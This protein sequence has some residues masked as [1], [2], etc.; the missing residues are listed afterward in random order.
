MMSNN[1]GSASVEFSSV[2]ASPFS[3]TSASPNWRITGAMIDCDGTLIDSIDA[4]RGI[5]EM[6]A[7]LVG[8]DVSPEERALFTTFTIPEV[9]R[10]FHERY[11][12]A[13]ST[14]EV[15]GII[16]DYM[17]DYYACQSCLLPGV[18]AFLESCASAGVKMC[19]VSSSPQV[20]LQA[21]LKHCG[22]EE[23]FSHIVS[24]E[25]LDTSKREARIFNHASSLL[26]TDKDTTWGVDDSLYVLETLKRAAYPS[27][28][29]Y[30]EKAGVSRHDA[31]DLATVA[32]ARL[33]ELYVKDATLKFS[34]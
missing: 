10:Y 2:N 28:G 11:A 20:Y 31:V 5:E 16:D 12:L 30:G 14:K 17:M 13:N 32:V 26:G 23:Y 21:G 9:S 19:V 4:W 8:V 34:A 1:A 3:G 18:E 6:L 15:I 24:V 7:H 25:D 33:D 27:I 22:I 29:L